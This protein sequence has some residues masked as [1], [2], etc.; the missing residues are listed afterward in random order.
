[1]CADP[2]LNDRFAEKPSGQSAEA[3]NAKAQR[4]ARAYLTGHAAEG[5]AER[6]YQ[7]LGFRI[8]ARRWRGDAGEIDLIV[9]RGALTVFAEVKCAACFAAAAERIRPAQMQRIAMAAEEYAATLPAGRLSDM[10]IDAVLVNGQ[11]ES[12]LIENAVGA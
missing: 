12:R 3:S 11:G 5:I 8:V 10:R 6:L 1:M 9:Q 2:P 4:G 7:A